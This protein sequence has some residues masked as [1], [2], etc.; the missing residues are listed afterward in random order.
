MGR[1]AHGLIVAILISLA[2]GTGSTVHASQLIKVRADDVDAIGLITQI[3][4]L[5]GQRIVVG[6]QDGSPRISLT[7]EANDGREL[8][9]LVARRLGW[10]VEQRDSF[11]VVGHFC[12]AVTGKLGPQYR[13]LLSLS[14]HDE[15]VGGVVELIQDFLGSLSPKA[16]TAAA[17]DRVSIQARDT[18]VFEFWNVLTAEPGSPGAQAC[19]HLTSPGRA[20]AAP[21]V[22]TLPVD[23]DF[24]PYRRR[25]DGELQRRR[26]CDPLEA[27]G[28]HSLS[29]KGY[30]A[31]NGQHRVLVETPDGSLGSASEGARLGRDFGK[32]TS[33]TER[34]LA[35]MEILQ[36][37]RGEWVER[38][39]DLAYGER[40][41]VDPWSRDRSYVQ[42]DSPQYAYEF[43][44]A[45]TATHA[46]RYP[47][48]IEHCAR[49]VPAFGPA[50]RM[51]L[52]RWREQNADVLKE[53]ALHLAAFEA[54]E[55]DDGVAVEDL[56]GK[57]VA[58]ALDQAVQ[59]LSLAYCRSMQPFAGADVPFD[60]PSLQTIRNCG[61]EGTCWRL[62]R[63]GD[64]ETGGRVD[65]PR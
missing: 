9:E 43:S 34:G 51:A 27:F 32:L 2:L 55:I 28:L 3:A 11:L 31:L 35:I 18:K 38:H 46:G 6:R 5:S 12:P 10:P 22:R 44:L 21:A 45:Q 24:C 64:V 61:N 50:L 47:R 40:V 59:S 16:S 23:V 36:N 48:E 60:R 26:R 15:S 63:S 14:F 52:D 54:S 1:L 25:R 20:G 7:A 29:F 30:V 37:E 58:R 13:T 41:A 19:A 4:G 65:L 56:A 33:V 17:T 62:V 57:R 53:A 39:H 49:L 8:I 42:P